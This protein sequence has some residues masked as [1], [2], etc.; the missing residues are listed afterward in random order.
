MPQRDLDKVNVVFSCRPLDADV[1]NDLGFNERGSRD[2]W[3]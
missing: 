2:V 3:W 1:R